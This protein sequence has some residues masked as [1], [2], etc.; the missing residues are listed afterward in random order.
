MQRQKR[1]EKELME[2]EFDVKVSTSS[3]ISK[4]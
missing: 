4:G 2:K 3:R 1:E